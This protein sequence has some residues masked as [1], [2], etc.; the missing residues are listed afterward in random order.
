MKRHSKQRA[1][2]AMVVG[3]VSVL[4]GAGCTDLPTGTR[5]VNVLP[6]SAALLTTFSNTGDIYFD[7]AASDCGFNATT[8]NIDCNFT[9]K[10]LP[11]GTDTFLS[12]H[13][14]WDVSVYCV[15]GKTGKLA[16]NKLQPASPIHTFSGG[17]SG[18]QRFDANGEYVWANYIIYPPGLSSS[19]FCPQRP[20]DT[21]VFGTP[22]PTSWA[23]HAWKAGDETGTFADMSGTIP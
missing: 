1:G 20:Y 7:P 23:L 22:L 4:L 5:N 10:G 11:P 6:P 19:Y 14:D 2:I 12:F 17:G 21:A 15:N 3:L 8:G 13:V 16:P 18:V 9:L